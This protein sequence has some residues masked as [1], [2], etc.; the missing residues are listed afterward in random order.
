VGIHQALG[1]DFNFV[2]VV[3][4][5]FDHIVLPT[6][7]MLEMVASSIN[8]L[9]R[10]GRWSLMAMCREWP[11]CPESLLTGFAHYGLSE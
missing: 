1:A 8:M 7:H 9:S 11:V 2:I 4:N 10:L 6:S 3:R 5:S